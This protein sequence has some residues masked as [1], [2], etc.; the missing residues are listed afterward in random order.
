MEVATEAPKLRQVGVAVGGVRIKS[1]LT[2]RGN[3]D[4]G[5][6]SIPSRFETTLLLG[7]REKDA[8]GGRTHR[9]S[10]DQTDIPGPGHY[11][12]GPPSMIRDPVT[13]GSVSYRG[14][15]TFA[16]KSGRFS[17]RKAFDDATMP[18]PGSYSKVDKHAVVD[19][20]HRKSD[21]MAI[22]AKP[23]NG[24]LRGQ[25]PLPA[26]VAPGPGTYIGLG[27]S[28]SK[29]RQREEARKSSNFVSTVNRFSDRS[30]VDKLAMPA[31]GAYNDD[32]A[33]RALK[34][35]GSVKNGLSSFYSSTQRSGGY[36]D[37]SKQAKLP[38]PGTY[39]S[40]DAFLAT[41]QDITLALH[42][43]SAFS[44]INLDR[45][46]KPYNPKT[47][48]GE[49]PGP[50]WYEPSAL[51]GGLG[52]DGIVGKPQGVFK[53]KS[54]RMHEE[55]KGTR[56]SRPPGP[57]FYRPVAPQHLK[58]SFMINSNKKWV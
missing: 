50:G 6:A 42:N 1:A 30:R 7:H 56:A 28:K 21:T 46:G 36:V 14:S 26:S 40:Q 41:K 23:V 35:Q 39:N 57:A 16:S 15:G 33:H 11:V 51:P 18:G 27:E 13:C 2:H 8:F 52:K 45:F 10:D 37:P 34:S 49:V 5:P 24:Y 44:N 17:D 38:G 53:S 4:K 31:P 20:D 32:D 54:S 58:K 48:N 47:D 9:F 12:N 25:E 55:P 29:R 43:S 3:L 19:M 22:F